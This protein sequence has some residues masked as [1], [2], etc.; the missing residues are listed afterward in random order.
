[1][2]FSLP[3]TG[4]DFNSSL[5][6]SEKLD[7]AKYFVPEGAAAPSLWEKASELPISVEDAFGPNA[8]DLAGAL[9]LDTSQFLGGLAGEAP[10]SWTFITAP[11]DVSWDVANAVSRV[12]VFGTNNPPVVAGSRGMRE[13]SLSNSLVEGFV[14]GVSLE[15]K[16]SAL[17]KL[18]NYGLNTSEGY[19]SVPVYQV[20]ANEKSYGGSEAY[21]VIKNVNVK[22][23]MRDLQGN[24]TRAY[25]D[26]SLVQVP[27][28]QVNSGRDQASQQTSTAGEALASSVVNQAG[29]NIPGNGSSTPATSPSAKPASGAGAPKPDVKGYQGGGGIGES[30]YSFEQ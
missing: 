28:Y 5:S 22:E 12:D 16:I 1:M 25:V 8:P 10:P 20:W 7:A 27:A 18:L 9:G 30:R 24:A 14:R 29:Q 4:F 26:I 11:E 17:E 15:G 6:A 2:A 19:V 13:L 21:Y 3:T 23:K